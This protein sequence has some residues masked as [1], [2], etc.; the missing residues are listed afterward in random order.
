M[1]GSP[2]R[3]V[4]RQGRGLGAATLALLAAVGAFGHD[5][6]GRRI[7]DGQKSRYKAIDGARFEPVNQRLVAGIFIGIVGTL[8]VAGDEM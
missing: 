6:G 8:A 7:L 1:A 4:H 5:R 2:P 3:A